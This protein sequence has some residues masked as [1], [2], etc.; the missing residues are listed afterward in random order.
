M[1]TREESAA[2]QAGEERLVA[3]IS[4]ALRD[5]YDERRQILGE[6][7]DAVAEPGAKARATGLL[8]A[9]LNESNRGVVIDSLRVDRSEKTDLVRDLPVVR[10]EFAEPKAGSAVLLPIPLRCG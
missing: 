10:Q 1:G 4:G 8:R 7:P 6:I 9:C 5:Q 2:P 3:L